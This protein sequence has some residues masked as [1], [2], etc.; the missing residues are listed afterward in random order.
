MNTKRLLTAILALSL[1]LSLFACGSTPEE[2]TSKVETT[3]ET[4]TTKE[5]EVTTEETTE[6]IT[7]EEITTEVTTTEETTTEE[8]TTE[9][10][11]TEKITTE[12]TA[13]EETTETEIE[14]T[15]RFDYFGADMNEY[16][17]MESDALESIELEISSEYLID[18]NDVKDVVNMLI[19]DYRTPLND[20]E[21]SV[22]QLVQ[23][24]DS[25]FIYFKGYIDGTEFEGGSNW[26]DEEPWELVIGSG[27]FIP[28]FE[29]QLIDTIPSSTSKENPV[30]ITVTFPEDY[31][32]EY[33]GK[34]AVFDVYVAYVVKYELPEYNADL[35]LGEFEYETEEGCTD[36][37]AEFEAAILEELQASADEMIEMEKEADLWEY[38]LESATVLQ[39]PQSEVDFY[40]NSFITLLEEYREFYAMMG[41]EFESFDEFAIAFLELEEGADWQVVALEDYVY[42][43][44][45]LHFVIQYVA[46]ELSIELTDDD[47]QASI[48]S[49]MNDYGLTEEEVLEQVGEDL[50]TE[51]A[52]RIKI[53]TLLLENATVV[54]N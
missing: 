40:Y 12:E 32:E 27:D 11:T 23:Y 42:T 28:G 2:T 16:I 35:I 41:M 8:I 14:E 24:G 44:I 19:F 26:D 43:E 37:V 45:K 39:Y 54:F 48:E 7:T 15:A 30:K 47:I 13:S 38:L 21:P 1:M 34:E 3:E 49:Y 17:S 36:V 29:D 51:N 33:A 25:A 52:L 31:L 50:L 18:E 5:T 4:T 53:T 46:D 20:E 9:E 6:A 10:I 22:T